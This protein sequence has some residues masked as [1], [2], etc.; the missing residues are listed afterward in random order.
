M[1]RMPLLTALAYLVHLLYILY[2]KNM[3]SPCD[4]AFLYPLFDAETLICLYLTMFYSLWMTG[5][6]GEHY[7]ERW[8][9][10][11]R[12]QD[13]LFTTLP[14]FFRTPSCSMIQFF[15]SSLWAKIIN[16]DSYE[17]NSH[18]VA[19]T[20]QTTESKGNKY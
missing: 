1:M 11:S 3:L 13:P 2:L 17:R 12:G 7:L 19:I 14:P 9:G 10:M 20:I 6:G 18:Q 16:F 8:Y 15:R 4:S 5:G